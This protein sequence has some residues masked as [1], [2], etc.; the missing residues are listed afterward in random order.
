M[1]VGRDGR[2]APSAS[3]MTTAP[4]SA[5]DTSFSAPAEGADRRAA[6][7]DD[8]GQRLD[9]ERH[10]TV[11]ATRA[12]RL[13]D[14]IARM[15]GDAFEF[16]GEIA[17][18]PSPDVDRAQPADGLHAPPRARRTS[19]RCSTAPS[20]IPSGSGARCSTISASSSTSR[21]RRSLDVST[22]AGLGALVRGR[23]ASTSSTTASTSGPAPPTDAR[24]AI[25]WEGEEGATAHADL[26]GAARRDEPLRQ[27]AAMRSAC[28]RATASR[29]SCRWGPSSP[30]P[31]SPS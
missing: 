20:P 12:A 3:R 24:P 28:A 5:A 31:S 23:R 16:G 11:I 7:A 10:A 26:R 25:R 13:L 9:L 17:W 15:A 2:R 21:S 29:S 4:R 18:R 27:R 6:R 8:H 14:K 1:A 30:P 19:R 22:R